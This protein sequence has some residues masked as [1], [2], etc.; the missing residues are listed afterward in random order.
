M[1]LS[2]F[3]LKGFSIPI[4][5]FLSSIFFQMWL[6]LLKTHKKFENELNTIESYYWMGLE[7]KGNYE[8]FLQGL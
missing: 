3:K 6:F 4:H 5:V 1:R 2:D 7:E 8:L